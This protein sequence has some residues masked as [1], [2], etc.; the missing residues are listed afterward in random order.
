MSSLNL[1]D[2]EKSLKEKGFRKKENDH[3]FYHYHSLN[4]EK[5]SIFTKVSHSGKEIG[6]NLIHCMSKQLKINISFLKKFIECSK[7]Q[8][9]YE[10]FLIEN[11]ILKLKKVE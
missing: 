1:V 5:T 2:V 10:L 4:G 9:D 8:S 6:D 7:S 11:S 3:T